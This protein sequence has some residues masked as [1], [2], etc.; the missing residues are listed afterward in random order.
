MKINSVLIPMVFILSIIISCTKSTNQQRIAVNKKMNIEANKY[1][2]SIEEEYNQYL[3]HAKTS[4][5]E[6]E[7]M[8]YI[9]KLPLMKKTIIE[10][11]GGIQNWDKYLAWLQKNDSRE[12]S[13]TSQG[14]P[15]F[16]RTT[17][18]ESNTIQ[19]KN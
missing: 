17:H 1:S 8:S 13:F 4:K 7:S 9:E 10:S 6:F 19:P 14:V 15:V 12:I 16:K 11:Y 3:Q 2:K 18:Y 5:S